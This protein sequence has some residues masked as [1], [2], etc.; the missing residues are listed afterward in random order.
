MV[1]PQPD[2]PMV[3]ER[4]GQTHTKCEAHNTEG[5]P[6]GRDPMRG[7]TV[8]YKHGGATQ[9]A[10]QAGLRRVAQQEA[11][12]KAQRMLGRMGV[13]ADPI[14]HLVECL[15]RSA[16]LTHVYGLMVAD[17]DNK[18]EVEAEDMPGR[19]RGWAEHTIELGPDG[20]RHVVASLD[21]LLVETSGET[22]QLHPFV[23][24]YHSALERTAK[25][26]KLCLDAGVAERQVRLA[27]R[28][29]EMI[30]QV[31]DAALKEVGL[32]GTQLEE[33]RRAA[34]REF[35]RLELTA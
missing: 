19:Q 28:T 22:V 29:G 6:C 17:L 23:K 27:E 1:P 15:H 30:V 33:A 21:P 16:M 8:C 5:N 4:C 13:D 10:R 26:A 11:M 20:K 34:G 24:E 35:R 32:T 2:E 12:D 18:G 31:L 9:A 25:M 7:Q 3:C 14:E